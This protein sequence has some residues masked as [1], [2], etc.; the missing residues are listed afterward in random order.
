M[1]LCPEALTPSQT[2]VKNSLQKI[3]L[4]IIYLAILFAVARLLDVVTWCV[5]GSLGP[6]DPMVLSVVQLKAILEW[7]GIRSDTAV[8]KSDLAQFVKQSGSI[9]RVEESI[10]QQLK[11]KPVSP[12]VEFESCGQYYH[13]VENNNKTTNGY[14]LVLV[15]AARNISRDDGSD[16]PPRSL[17]YWTV[18]RKELGKLGV[19]TGVLDCNLDPK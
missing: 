5:T 1:R 14:W 3:F 18:L 9:S 4:F 13:L 8:E 6:L 2:V 17:K 11:D 15:K 7:R 10:L 19:Q 12:D 16:A